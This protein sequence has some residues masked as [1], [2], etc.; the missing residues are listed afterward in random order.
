M[1]VELFKDAE[2][3]KL[4]EP[5]D[6]LCVAPSIALIAFGLYLTYASESEKKLRPEGAAPGEKNG[7]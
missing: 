7:G 1:I 5:I 6:L 2:K 4:N 3:I